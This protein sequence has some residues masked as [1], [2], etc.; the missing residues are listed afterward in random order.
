[1]Q[2]FQEDRLLYEYEE[3]LKNLVVLASFW[4]QFP[5]GKSAMRVSDTHTSSPDWMGMWYFPLLQ[6]LFEL[7]NHTT[8]D[9]TVH[10]LTNKVVDTEEEL[11]AVEDDAEKCL[12]SESIHFVV[13]LISNYS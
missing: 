6:T 10:F 5:G 11:M 12:L 3:T 1:M 7:Q 9:L 13:T 8:G 2:W 4:R